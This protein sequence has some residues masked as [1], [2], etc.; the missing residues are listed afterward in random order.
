MPSRPGEEQGPPSALGGLIEVTGHWGWLLVI[1]ALELVTGIIAVSYPGV[2]V[3]ALSI[4][5][6]VGLLVLGAVTF[7]TAMQ[8][9]AGMP[10]RGWATFMAILAVVGGLIAL[11]RPG[12]GIYAI[13]VALALWFFV[14]GLND[15][16]RASSTPVPW[17][18][19]VIGVLSIIAATIVLFDPWAGITVVAVVVGLWF[20]VRGALHGYAAFEMRRIHRAATRPPT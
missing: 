9:P 5:V 15:L 11:F 7:A 12:A 20:M 3:F 18:T 19:A 4:V 16:A 8:V 14:T 6:G 17:L 1:A 13:L 10:G 2:T